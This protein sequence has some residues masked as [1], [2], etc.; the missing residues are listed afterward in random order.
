MFYSNKD[1][2]V[3]IQNLV[4]FAFILLGVEKRL[5][6]DEIALWELGAKIIQKVARKV[7][8]SGATILQLLSDRIISGGSSVSQYTGDTLY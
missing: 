3:I 7:H 8:E 2:K 6:H 4:T 1:R 5:N